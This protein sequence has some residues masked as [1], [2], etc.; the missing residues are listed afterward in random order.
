MMS[1]TCPDQCLAC[2]NPF[3]YVNSNFCLSIITNVVIA[4]NAVLF[5]LCPSDSS[6]ATAE[7][8][9]KLFLSSMS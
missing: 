4:D 8:Y 1:M 5:K 3:S 9:S 6:A 2:Y 7:D